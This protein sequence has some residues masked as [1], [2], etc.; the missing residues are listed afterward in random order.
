[1]T[2]ELKEQLKEI[3]AELYVIKVAARN[4]DDPETIDLALF[5]AIRHLDELIEK[6]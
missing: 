3:S 6:G 4:V 1:M 2:D 5:A